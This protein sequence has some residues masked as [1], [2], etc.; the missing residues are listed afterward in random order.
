MARPTKWNASLQQRIVTYILAGSY[1][2]TAAK[3]ADVHKDT[4]YDWL[5]RGAR[6]EEPYAGFSDAVEK[7][8]AEAEIR[9]LARID[10]AA[11]AHWQAAAWKLE[12]RNPKMWG[13]REYT[14]LTGADGGPITHAD[15]TDR[16]DADLV[17]EAEAIARRAAAVG[18]GGAPGA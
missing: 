13:R 17:A 16:T 3:A 7:A 12:R 1:I 9:D 10:K 4:L 14:E 6:G 5:Q 18:S 2:E 15:L 11:D 8:L